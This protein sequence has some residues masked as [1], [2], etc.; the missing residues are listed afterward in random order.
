MCYHSNKLSHWQDCTIL[1]VHT[2]CRQQMQPLSCEG[3]V[4]VLVAGVKETPPWLRQRGAASLDLG[5]WWWRRGGVEMMVMA[6][7]FCC[8]LC[9]PICCVIFFVITFVWSTSNRS[10]CCTFS[11][12]FL[13]PCSFLVVSVIFGITI[14]PSSSLNLFSTMM[15]AQY[16]GGFKLQCSIYQPL[17]LPFCF[18]EATCIFL[19]HIL[20][21]T[22]AVVTIRVTE[23][24]DLINKAWICLGASP[25][26]PLVL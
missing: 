7:L 19:S 23:R 10:V 2:G 4:A 12:C 14:W 8:N 1:V 13:G 17:R 16:S 18:V 3:C 15:C 5:G 9:C 6:A 22:S 26:G 11:A 25:W 24:K 20:K 21:H